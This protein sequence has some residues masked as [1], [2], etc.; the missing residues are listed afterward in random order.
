MRHGI[1][2]VLAAVICS[3]MIGCLSIEGEGDVGTHEQAIINGIPT[4]ERP[5]VGIITNSGCTATLIRPRV[6]LTAAHCVNY[7]TGPRSDGFLTGNGEFFAIDYVS[8]RISSGLGW[9]DLAVARLTSAVPPSSAVPTPNAYGDAGANEVVTV[10]GYGC[11]DRVSEVGYGTK[12][13]YTFPYYMRYQLDLLCPGDSGGPTI[14]PSRGVVQVNS[15]YYLEG[16]DIY[17]SVADNHSW[18][19]NWADYFNG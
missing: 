11:T 9:G 14:L 7:Q 4:N 3:G 18:V 8:S 10:Y 19:S 15:G 5:E 13:K 1:S 2:G 6:I 16:G 12:R 17:G